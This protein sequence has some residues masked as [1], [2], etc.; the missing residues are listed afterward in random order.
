MSANSD[1]SRLDISDFMAE[2]NPDDIIKTS[3]LA[4]N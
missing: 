1:A 2:I 4:T 3:P